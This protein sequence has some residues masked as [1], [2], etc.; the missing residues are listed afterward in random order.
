MTEGPDAAPVAVCADADPLNLASD[1][2]IRKV[3]KALGVDSGKVRF[4]GCPGLR[5]SAE[6]MVMGS[7]RQYV[8]TYPVD[9]A[10]TY[11]APVTH[12]LAH[13]LQM[14]IAGGLTALRQTPSKKIEL[15]ADF[16]TGIVFSRELPK[17]GLDEFQNNLSLSGKYVEL[18]VGA[19]G[20]PDQRAA[21]FRTG[22]YWKCDAGKCDMRSLLDKFNWDL[23]API[24][25]F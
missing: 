8:I 23:Y 21:A 22:A 12:E 5:F 14:E 6:S 16:L 1:P 4:K 15:G 10:G 24:E 9:A 2:D 25:Q 20:R 18:E 3:M 19:H 7:G 13:V 11:L 17:A